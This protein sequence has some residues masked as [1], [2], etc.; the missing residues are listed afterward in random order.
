MIESGPTRR[1]RR[2]A[3]ALPMNLV[4]FR[5]AATIFVL[6]AALSGFADPA[7][8]NP[9]TE[10]KKRLFGQRPAASPVRD[11]V[12]EGP[13]VLGPERPER[14]V[15]DANAPERDFPEGRSRYREI[16]LPREYAHAALRVQVIAQPRSKGHGNGVFKPILYLLGDDGRLG[17]T[18]KVEPLLLDIRPFQP[19]RLLAC[20]PLE[21]VRR[22]ALA[23]PSNAD[24]HSYQSAARDKVNAS[25]KKGFY[26][27]TDTVKATLPYDEVGQVVLEFTSESA[28]GKGCK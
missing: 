10:W 20:V 12:A 1:A 8:A 25:S 13:I 19:T 9:L 3:L 7:Q 21:K 27:S 26:Y 2:V 5:I 23:T 24:S 4:A 18:V 14:V 17:K 11:A 6:L 15:I 28:E 16:E 22:F